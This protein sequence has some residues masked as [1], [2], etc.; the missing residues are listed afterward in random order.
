MPKTIPYAVALRTDFR[1]TTDTAFILNEHLETVIAVKTRGS[2]ESFH[3]KIDHSQP[4]WN[5]G[6][7]NMILDLHGW[8]QSTELA[9][10]LHAG[11][12]V[13]IRG[14]SSINTRVGLA[15]LTKLSERVD[16]DIV[17]VSSRWLSRWCLRS[18][19]TLGEAENPK[20]LPRVAGE[21]EAACPFCKRT[22]LRQLP[23]SGTIRCVDPK[24]RDDEGRR[25]LAHLELFMGEFVLRWQDSVIG[26]P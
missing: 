26:A 15:A 17:Q 21:K 22:T 2:S 12:P 7:A 14:G 20:R 18:R 1:H 23:L 6:V 16:D 8:T 24:C 11:F 4:P 19:V 13:R 25:P 5:A 3:G 9:W 10:R